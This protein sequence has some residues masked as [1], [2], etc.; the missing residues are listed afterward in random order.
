MKPNLQSAAEALHHSQQAQLK[1]DRRAARRFAEEAV[2]LAPEWEDA[3]LMLAA[4]A[5]PR[6]SVAYIEQALKINPQS[7]ARPRG[8]ALGG[9]P[10]PDA[11][12]TSHAKI[13]AR[14]AGFP[15]HPLAAS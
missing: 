13:Q 12:T 3:W 15:D 4:L 7:D 8:H 2:R 5:E 11:K 14:S 6:A 9:Q 1:G 10:H